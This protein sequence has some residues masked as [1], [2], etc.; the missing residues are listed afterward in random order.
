[1]TS[2]NVSLDVG[3]WVGVMTVTVGVSEDVHLF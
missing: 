3:G 2:F 1:M